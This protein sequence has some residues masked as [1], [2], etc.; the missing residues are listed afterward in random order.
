MRDW[1]EPYPIYIIVH[2][3]RH[4]VELWQDSDSCARVRERCLASEAMH[5]YSTGQFVAFP[6]LCLI[7]WGYTGQEAQ[8]RADC[9]CYILLAPHLNKLTTSHLL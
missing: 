4:G 8:E 7:L 3:V 5:Q 2:D 9:H 1:R 6:K